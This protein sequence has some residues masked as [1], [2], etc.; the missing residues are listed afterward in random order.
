MSNPGQCHR[1]RRQELR[2]L[3]ENKAGAHVLATQLRLYDIGDLTTRLIA[4]LERRD[5][6]R[7]WVMELR[8]SEGAIHNTGEAF[9]TYYEHRFSSTT[10][11]SGAD[12]ADLLKDVSLWVLYREDRVH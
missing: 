3:T 5:R 9:A 7:T 10:I 11:R 4:C 1:F 6:G 8:D 2:D 12:R